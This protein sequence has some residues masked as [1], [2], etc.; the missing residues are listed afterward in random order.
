[1]ASRPHVSRRTFLKGAATLAAF[2]V[3]AANVLGANETLH[4]GCRSE[5]HTSELQSLRHLVCRLL[6]EK[7]KTHNNIATHPRTREYLP[8][9]RHM[10]QLFKHDD[11]VIVYHFLPPVRRDTRLCIYTASKSTRATH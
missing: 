8:N 4:I 11:K 1:M 9:L 10:I 5:E 3:P 2:G 6:L 7:K